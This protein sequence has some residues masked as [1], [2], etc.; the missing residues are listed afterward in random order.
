MLVVALVFA[1]CDIGSAASE[2][3]GDEATAVSS[4]ATIP[5]Y[6]KGVDIS[7]AYYA[8][9]K[10][11][12]FK[13]T[14][15]TAKAPLQI[16]KDHGYT[17]ARV[18]LMV[19][20]TTDYALF[21]DITYVKAAAKDIKA[22]GMK[23]LLDLHYSHWWAD[24]SNQ[25]IPS[26]WKSY[27]TASTLAS[28]VRSYTKDVMAQLVAQGTP[29][30]MVQIGN[31]V[32]NGMLWE[33]GRLSSLS[34]FATLEAAGAN[35][36]KD[37]KGSAAMPPIMVHVAKD[38]SA[39]AAVTWYKNFINAGGW[40]DAIGLS[41]Y[42]MWHGSQTDLSNT[43]KAL[44]SA[45]SWAPVWVVETAYY[46]STNQGGYTGSQVPYAQT[47]AGQAAF[48]AATKSTVVNAG[49]SGI[50]YWGAF[51]AQSS[52]WLNAPGWSNDDASRRSL[53]NDSAVAQVGIDSL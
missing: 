28:A 24:P 25:W 22:K 52:K 48:L 16:F 44:R 31:E 41:Y 36:I 30:D 42:P 4:R 5:S 7:E 38:M 23:F 32:N 1:S 12:S 49:G 45:Y 33:I 35:G 53:F 15:G 43:I 34:A 27:T 18:R 20:G 14:N 40:V 9:S 11:V 8:A 19:D 21:Q 39:S 2:A 10:G 50:F 37:G 17:W 46:W 6:T 3:E 13:D 47:P 26:R 51:W 29:P